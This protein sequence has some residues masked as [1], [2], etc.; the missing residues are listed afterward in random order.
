MIDIKKLV[1]EYFES[2]GKGGLP[3]DIKR[4]FLFLCETNNWDPWSGEAYII[5]FNNN[6]NNKLEWKIVNGYPLLILVFSLALT[7]ISFYLH[8]SNIQ[9]ILAGEELKIRAVLFKKK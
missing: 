8:R 1:Q 7:L 2:F 6:K 9:R 4:R 5:P 3:D